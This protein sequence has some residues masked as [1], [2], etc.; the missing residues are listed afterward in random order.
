M[1]SKKQN[2]NSLKGVSSHLVI[3]PL[4]K[5]KSKNKMN[6][7]LSVPEMRSIR[8][9]LPKTVL[10]LYCISKRP[11]GVWIMLWLVDTEACDRWVCVA[12]MYSTFVYKIFSYGQAGRGFGIRMRPFDECKFQ[13]QRNELWKRV[14]L[15]RDIQWSFCCVTWLW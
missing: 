4:N 11:T 8:H 3:Q 15:H 2:G 10:I 5:K 14:A 9:I 1:K 6:L 13:M 7:N 12:Y